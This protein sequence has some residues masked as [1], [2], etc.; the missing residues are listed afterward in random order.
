MIGNA[1]KGDRIATGQEPE[2]GPP[3]PRICARLQVVTH[4]DILAASLLFHVRPTNGVI[5]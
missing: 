2:T 5:C 4:V 3:A 1:V